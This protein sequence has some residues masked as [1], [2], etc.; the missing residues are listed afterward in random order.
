MFICILGK[1][2]QYVFDPDKRNDVQQRLNRFV[3]IH[4]ALTKLFVS[5]SSTWDVALQNAFMYLL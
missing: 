5:Q 3:D 2:T 4:K 1:A